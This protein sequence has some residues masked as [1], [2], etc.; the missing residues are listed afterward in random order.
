MALAVVC[1]RAFA[2][3][4]V[5][6]TDE[7]DFDSAFND[8]TLR[9]DYVFGGTPSTPTVALA[10]AW[11]LDGW[12]GRRHNLDRYLLHGNGRVTVTGVDGD[13]LYINT[14]SS[15]YS[16][17]LE[18]NDSVS[19]AFQ[20][21][22]L[23]PLPRSEANIDLTLYDGRQ[24]PIVS[25][26]YKYRPGDYLVRVKKSAGYIVNAIH[27]GN[28]PGTHINVAILPEGFTADEMQRF[29][30]LAR[31]AVSAI[32]SHQPFADMADRFD[33]RTIEVPS[34]ESGVTVP[35]LGQWRDSAFGS[36]FSTFYSDR[37][38]TT[39]NVFAMHDA[40]AGV[41]YEHIIVL[42]N[43]DEYGGGGIYNSY[44]LTTTG[45][46]SFRPVVVHE[47]G[48]S[49][50]G[51]ADEY[52]YETDTMTDVY[53]T[54]VEPWEPNVTALVDFDAKWRDMLTPG[55]PVPTPVDQTDTFPVGVYEGAA[56]STHGLYRGADRCRM[57]VNDI[58]RFCPVC[59]RALRRLIIFLTQLDNN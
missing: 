26:C 52:F 30:S 44:T 12:S 47:F 50:G 25:H 7:V 31:V 10:D 36:H 2:A 9:L 48:H 22:V 59:Q 46:P 56:Y 55:T 11:R 13:T 17:W 51:L 42:A 57:R 27:T 43:V 14:F 29:D 58:D 49:F 21:T 24:Q 23:V 40:L 18:L 20:H 3:G 37:Y 4:A 35:R 39:P 45:H 53:A 1:L 32:L 6:F 41:P 5:A 54:D 38:L 34:A 15:L 19:R 16:E 33:F 8:S 28:W